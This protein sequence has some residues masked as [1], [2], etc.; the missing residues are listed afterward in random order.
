VCNNACMN[1]YMGMQASLHLL[2]AD[3]LPCGLGVTACFMHFQHSSTCFYDY[4]IS[5]FAML[6]CGIT[7]SGT[8]PYLSC[9]HYKLACQPC[10]IQQ[11][12]GR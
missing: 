5:G 4:I 9:A 11:N 3:Y 6:V 7:C 12:H 10:V 1:M 2:I 8:H